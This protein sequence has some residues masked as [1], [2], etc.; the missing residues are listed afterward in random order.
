MIDQL[1]AEDFTF[2]GPE[3]PE[4]RPHL[5]HSGRFKVLGAKG[6]L[7]KKSLL[8]QFEH[9]AEPKEFKHK[10]YTVMNV[11]PSVL[12]TYIPSAR[13]FSYN[14]SGVELED[15]MEFS[16][17]KRLPLPQDPADDDDEDDLKGKKDCKKP[18]NEDKPRCTFKRKPR[19]SSPESPSRSNKPLTPL[20]Y[21]QFYLPDLED[22]KT[23]PKFKVEYTT[24]KAKELLP[25]NVSGEK[26]SQPPPVPYHLLPGWDS[27]IGKLSAEEMKRLDEDTFDDRS[28]D[29]LKG[30]KSP[31]DKFLKEIKKI[32]PFK[33]KDL[34]INSYIKL[35]RVLLDDKK[36][37]GKFMDYM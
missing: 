4:G 22:Q 2:F 3:L 17:V 1:T 11:G 30:K 36:L 8:D 12:P 28:D 33:M 6:D 18:E 20:G 9:F 19:Y 26:R 10:D 27:S 15:E 29:E 32:T 34:T 14:I 16:R 13:I 23:P 5:L 21:T 37:W 7:L 25:P 31:K 24:F 35:G